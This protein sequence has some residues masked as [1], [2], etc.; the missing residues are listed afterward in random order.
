MSDIL[1]VN[2]VLF[3]NRGAW[4]VKNL[5]EIGYSG[6]KH[7]KELVSSSRGLSIFSREDVQGVF[8]VLEVREDF[9]YPIFLKIPIEKPS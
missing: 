2:D 5:Q 8:I 4:G 3:K 9:Q 6:D 7:L 1:G